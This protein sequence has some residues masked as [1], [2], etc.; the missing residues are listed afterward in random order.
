MGVGR[1]YTEA[2]ERSLL[3]GRGMMTLQE[4]PSLPTVL[5]S[6]VRLASANHT[7]DRIA[8]ESYV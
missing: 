1:H 3:H 6:Q 4:S 5:S 7:M 2:T 8:Q